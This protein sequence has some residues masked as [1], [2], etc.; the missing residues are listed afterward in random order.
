MDDSYLFSDLDTQPPGDADAQSCSGAPPDPLP[1]EEQLLAVR[2]RI[3]AGSTEADI[4]AHLR[5][6]VKRVK[7]LFRRELKSSAAEA[8]HEVLSKLYAAAKSGDNNT[9]AIFWAKARYGWRDTGAADPA[10]LQNWPRLD[11][12]IRSDSSQ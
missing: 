7:R 11:V 9:A 3:M 5:M 1:T 6:S 12:K 4:A 10:A 8:K 2:E